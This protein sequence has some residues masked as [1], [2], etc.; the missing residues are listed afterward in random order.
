MIPEGQR[1]RSQELNSEN[2]TSALLTT[3]NFMDFTETKYE[4]LVQYS[5]K[6]ITRVLI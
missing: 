5:L 6:N 1:S 4:H 2:H 3:L